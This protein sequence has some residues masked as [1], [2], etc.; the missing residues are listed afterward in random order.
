LNNSNLTNLDNDEESEPKKMVSEKTLKTNDMNS[1]KN[2]SNVNKSTHSFSTK[3]SNTST[4]KV[5][6]IRSQKIQ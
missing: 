1:T 3:K 5:N 6:L 4:E 2:D